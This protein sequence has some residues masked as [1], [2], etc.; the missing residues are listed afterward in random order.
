[1]DFRK[2]NQEL[3]NADLLLIDQILKGRFDPKMKILDAGCGEGRNMVYF[4][5]NGF[6]IYGIDQ[7]PEMVSMSRLIARAINKD[8]VVENIFTASIEE[9]PFP[10]KFFDVI[11]CINVLHFARDKEHFM[12]MVKSQLR[13]LRNGGLFYIGMESGSEMEEGKKKIAINREGATEQK[14][15]LMNSDLLKNLLSLNLMEKSEPVW[16]LH[17]EG[18][19]SLTGI[20]FKK[21]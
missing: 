13:V 14:R 17:L 9:N 21:I 11:L 19:V 6:P 12:Q 20:M 16:T 2:L 7:N 3:G 5:K 18:M 4:I 15:F 8:Y 1:M 10:D